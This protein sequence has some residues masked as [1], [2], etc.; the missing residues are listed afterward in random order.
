MTKSFHEI[1]VTEISGGEWRVC[2]QWEQGAPTQALL[3]GQA[4][5]RADEAGRVG[6]EELWRRLR[7][8]ADEAETR[9]RKAAPRR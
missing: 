1:T 7:R 6:D 4:R 2:V 8:A 9:T 5:A 3:P